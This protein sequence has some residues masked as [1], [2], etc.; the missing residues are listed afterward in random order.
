MQLRRAVA[1]ELRSFKNTSVEVEGEIVEA[2]AKDR[3]VALERSSFKKHPDAPLA[4]VVNRKITKR[5]E[6]QVQPEKPVSFPELE[7]RLRTEA[8]LLRKLRRK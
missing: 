6:L 7:E 2:R 3:M 8:R 4:T 5:K 1:E